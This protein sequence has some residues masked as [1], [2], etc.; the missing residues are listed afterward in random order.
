MPRPDKYQHHIDGLRAVAILCVVFFHY[1]QSTFSGGFVGVDVFFVISGYL[2]SNL[3]LSEISD[4]ENFDFKRFYIRRLRR[5]FPALLATLVFSLFFSIAL[6]SPE[7]LQ[8]YGRTLTASVFS[9]SNI[10]FWLDSGYFDNGSH[11]KPLLHT[12]SLSVEE[13]F[14]L[15]WPALLWF[16]ARG[17]GR[18]SQLI[19]LILVGSLSFGLNYLWVNSQFDPKFRSTLFYLTPFRI[20]ELAI[21]ALAIFLPR[22]ISTRRWVHEVLMATGL[23]M[24]AYAA[25]N[26][27]SEVVFPY[28]AALLPCVGALLVI[29]SPGSVLVGALLNNRLAVGIGLIS[30]SLYLIHWPVLVFYEHY[31]F[32]PLDQTEYFALFTLSIVLSILMYHLIE[33]PFRKNSPTRQSAYPQRLFVSCCIAI[34][35]LL[36]ITGFFIGQSDGKIWSNSKGLSTNE[37]RLASQKRYELVR[38]GC[39]LL[40]LEKSRYCQRGKSKQILIIGNSHEP[41]GFNIFSQ[42]YRSNPN[43]N[44]I[45]FGSLNSCNVS[46]ETGIPISKVRH[47]RCDKRTAILADKLFLDSLDGIVLSA[48]KPFGINQRSAWKILALIQKTNPDIPLVVLGGYINTT[49]RCSDLYHHFGSFAACK[50]PLQISYN[51]FNERESPEV[52]GSST[53]DYLYIDKTKLLC[54]HQTI[55]SCIV[56]VN[57]EPAF[58]DWHHLSMD[59]SL[60]LGKRVAQEYGKELRVWGFPAVI[61]P[62]LRPGPAKTGKMRQ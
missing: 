60:Y 5:L 56:A 39:S 51:P 16:F 40:R 49:Q 15:L 24:I 62:K 48:N 21:G 41:D 18:Q 3:I 22:M 57:S 47:R 7:Q 55:K 13:Q 14:Y 50:D 54:R 9:V 46:L 17:R 44:L 53:L 34:C 26:Y 25:L 33:K 37:I 32:L 4:T 45:S 12:W 29:V 42:V 11:S 36:G 6:L 38:S 2:I 30:Y 20:F 31:T 19:L 10:Q 8:N 1:G 27:S 23:L 28:T 58:Y 35:F 61:K 43:V 59:F 52:E